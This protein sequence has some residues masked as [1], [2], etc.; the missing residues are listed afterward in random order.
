MEE[1]RTIGKINSKALIAGLLLLA[2]GSLSL[3]YWG[4]Q[5][6]VWFCDEIYTYESSNG[7]E[8]DWPA[9][10]TGQW[11][12]GRDVEA[13]FAA[14]GD[15]LS[16][17]DITVRLYNDHVPLY[18]WLFRMVSFFF[19]KGSGTIWIG[20]SINLFFY[21][22][23][24]VLGYRLF[25][26]LTG[27]PFLSCLVMLLT[28]VVNRLIIEQITVL[29]MYMMLLLAQGMLLLAGFWILREVE[30]EKISPRVFVYLFGVSLFGFLTH[31]DYWIFYAAA[32]SVF[33]LWLLIAAV[34]KKK[35]RFWSSSEFRY[36]LAWT[37]NFLLAL[38]A[39]IWL[40]P[41]CRWNLNKGKGQTALLSLFDFSG[42]KWE[43]II[44]GY[45]SL[46]AAMF[47]DTVPAAVGLLSVFGCIIG[48][49]FLLYRRKEYKKSVGLCLSVLTAQLY[50]LVVCFT[51]PA[52]LEERYLWGEFVIMALC[53]AYG[54]LL[55]MENCFAAV[56]DMKKQLKVRR[57]T[58]VLLS[59]LILIGEISVI[60]GG[61]GVTY[62]FREEK[63]V[64]ILR[65]NS[66]IPWVVYGAAA[67]VY[68]YYDWLIPEKICFLT[69]NNMPEDGA[70][71][72]ELQ[73]EKFILYI[74]QDYLPAAL[75]FFE[76][77]LGRELEAAYLTQS[78]NFTVYLVE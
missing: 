27:R 77:E 11:M 32:A 22:I 55:M 38:L 48:G 53:M 6:Q 68:S 50:Q 45:R 34:R 23:F 24:L 21:L 40:F 71:V 36:V 60:D 43:K 33:C 47:G 1:K 69:E 76:Q 75:T 49:I 31:Y 16:L 44:W 20:L 13:F 51:M 29:R 7:F 65:A 66:E 8:Q 56:H 19:F 2:A 70:A 73:N 42:E 14:D 28:C 72:K 37:V 67:D 35:K 12:S 17:N 10:C 74:Y 61:R 63:D 41:Y 5:K 30:K 4:M 59:V 3:L 9:A 18:F 64:N 78:T 58:A 54:A 15:T 46:S 52:G 26:R 25:L 39:A 62:L 57:L